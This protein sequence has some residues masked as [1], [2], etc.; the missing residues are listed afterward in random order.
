MSSVNKQFGALLT[1]GIATLL[2]SSCCVGPLLLVTVGLGGAWV[3]KL[4]LLEPY[5]PIFL[6]IATLAMLFAYRRI[7]RPLA[8]CRPGEM[9][10]VPRVR[11]FYQL[12][13]WSVLLLIVLTLAFPW[14]APAFY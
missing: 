11:L 14:L 7:F 13:F 6:G 5:Q 3:G 12:L 10:A 2:A 8:A 9:C 1:A 4:Q